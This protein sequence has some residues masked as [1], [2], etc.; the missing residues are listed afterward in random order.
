MWVPSYYIKKTYIT[1][2]VYRCVKDSCGSC[3][4]SNPLW[5]CGWC[6]SKAMCTKNEDCSKNWLQATSKS[7]VCRNPKI[8]SVSDCLTQKGPFILYLTF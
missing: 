6:E 4:Q 8:Y 7:Q 2:E 1:V 5:Q 3:L